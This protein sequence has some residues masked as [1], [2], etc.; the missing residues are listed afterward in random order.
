MDSENAHTT[1]RDLPITSQNISVRNGL[2]DRANVFCKHYSLHCT[3]TLYNNIWV[4]TLRSD[5]TYDDHYLGRRRR[6]DMLHLF[7]YS[8]VQ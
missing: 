3:Q 8:R 2:D 5:T 6:T 4:I 1:D 7:Y